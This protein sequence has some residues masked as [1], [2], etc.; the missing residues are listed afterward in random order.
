MRKWP[1]LV[2]LSPI[3]LSQAAI[4]LATPTAD[5]I[6]QQ[7]NIRRGLVVVIDDDAD[8]GIALAKAEPLVVHVLL[9]SAA[10]PAARARIV[11]ANLHGQVTVSEWE[12]GPL[13][14][15]ENLAAL[16]VVDLE[17]EPKIEREE[18]LRVVRPGG[19]LLAK[20]DGRWSVV[21]KPR[22]EG[23]DDWPQYHYNAAMTDRSGDLLP[24]QR[25]ASSGW[26]QELHPEREDRRADHGLDSFCSP[27]NVELSP[28]TRLAGC[29][30]WSASDLQVDNRY[31]LLVDEKRVYLVPRPEDQRECPA[32]NARDWIFTPGKQID[33]IPRRDS[34]GLGL[35]RHDGGSMKVSIVRTEQSQQDSRACDQNLRGIQARLDDGV[36]LQ[37]LDHQLV[38]LD[39]AS[40][41][42]LWVERTY[43]CLGQSTIPAVANGSKCATPGIIR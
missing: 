8:L 27:T 1:I 16:V 26:R 29:R 43:R 18:L 3:F 13:P 37:S 24:G 36:L 30:I 21:E 42:R 7:A 15:I 11:D 33:R 32:G 39:A 14:L 40:G 17:R 19:K 25:R 23:V 31:A 9:A 35:G 6:F 4:S 10:T 28:A 38:A 20:Q 22:P 34:A 2:L 12:E 5:E 41:N